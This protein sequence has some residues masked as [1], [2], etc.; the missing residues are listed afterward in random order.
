MQKK[1]LSGLFALALLS[2]A[3]FG[4]NK[5]LK[6]DA[7]LS[8]LALANVEALAENEYPEFWENCAGSWDRKR[9]VCGNRAFTFAVAVKNPPCYTDDMLY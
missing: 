2:T 7:N 3:G 8:D 6:S 5:S 1:I 4:V 9:C